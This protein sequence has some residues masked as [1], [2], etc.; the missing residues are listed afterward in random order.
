MKYFY[1]VSFVI[2][3]CFMLSACQKSENKLQGYVDADYTYIAS[4][5]AGHL[6][7]LS[8]AR[9]ASITKGQH[10]FTLD[11]QPEKSELL[12]AEAHVA[13]AMAKMKQQKVDMDYQA[14]TYAR[15][16][17][18]V[19]TSGVSKEE[20]ETVRNNYQ[21]AGATFKTM[22]ASLQASLAELEQA[23]W[24]QS[25][26]VVAAPVTGYVHDTYYTVGELVDRGRPV[27]SI[28]APENIKVVFFLEERLLSSLKLNQAVKITCD[29][30]K[31]VTAFVTYIS[32]QTEYTPP[33][34]YSEQTRDK[35]IFRI[36]A[37]PEKTSGLALHPGQPVTVNIG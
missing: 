4:N 12:I 15:Y 3:A 11:A 27:L 36:E 23:K 26:K 10:L 22:Q 20:F 31:P 5:Y 14:Q 2:F 19:K 1:Q 30:C 18:L 34:I 28:L 6:M 24:T 35:F 8:V 9:G 16:Q 33:N 13:E 32:S 29:G 21:N 7:Q 17:K 37:K 25:N